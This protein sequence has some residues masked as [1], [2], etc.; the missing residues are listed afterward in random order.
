MLQG[1]PRLF[2]S[3][4]GIVRQQSTFGQYGTIYWLEGWGLREQQ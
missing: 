4:R 3:T 2:E 1:F